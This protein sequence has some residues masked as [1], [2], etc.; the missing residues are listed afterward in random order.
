MSTAGWPAI[1][2]FLGISFGISWGYVI[3][4]DALLAA[5]LAGS[6]VGRIA[7]Y[8]AAWGPLI[9]ITVVIR[10]SNVS[11]RDWLASHVTLSEPLRLYVFALLVPNIVSTGAM[12][13]FLFVDGGLQVSFSPGN[14]VLVFGFTLVLFGA[15]E[16]FGWRGFLQPALQKR[17]TPVLAA[18]LVGSIWACWHLPS[19]LMGHLG[20]NPLGLFVLHLLPMSVIMAWLY[21]RSEGLL[22]VLVFHAAHNA[23]GNVLGTVGPTAPGAGDRY[24]LVYVG[25]WLLLA[26]VVLVV[27]GPSLGSPE[28][29]TGWRRSTVA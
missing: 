15:L 23:P 8:L 11:V 7:P 28:S 5:R 21:N 3:V 10:Y 2:A 29:A 19:Y 9:A 1:S 20:S 22:P 13:V 4:Y 27:A 6:T 17:V 24:Y 18:L 25:I 16:E 26:A 14:F 12:L